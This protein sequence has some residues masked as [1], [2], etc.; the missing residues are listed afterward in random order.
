MHGSDSYIIKPSKTGGISLLWQEV[1]TNNMSV[2]EKSIKHSGDCRYHVLC[3]MELYIDNC[4]SQYTKCRLLRCWSHMTRHWWDFITDKETA[5]CTP[6]ALKIITIT[7]SRSKIVQ[8][9]EVLCSL[10]KDR[11]TGPLCFTEDAIMHTMQLHILLETSTWSGSIA[12]Y[13]L[14]N[15]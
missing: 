4:T 7:K 14:P 11:I 3:C 12:G 1:Y 13:H 6:V 2:H 5:Q 9:M 15:A 10:M 8:K